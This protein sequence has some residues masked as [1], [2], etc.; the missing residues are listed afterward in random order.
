ML[1]FNHWCVGEL[2]P[3]VGPLHGLGR[4]ENGLQ[5]VLVDLKWT[6]EERRRGGDRRVTP[7]HLMSHHIPHG[8]SYSGLGYLGYDYTTHLYDAS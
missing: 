7:A 2:L 5:E 3:P 8:H 4:S 6:E 1:A